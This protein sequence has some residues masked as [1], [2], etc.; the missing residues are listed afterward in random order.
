M[1]GAH[2]EHDA[3]VGETVGLVARGDGGDDVVPVPAA[4][5]VLGGAVGEVV[6]G[7]AGGAEVGCGCG[8]HQW[9]DLR[10]SAGAVEAPLYST[11]IP[12]SG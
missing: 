4:E 9:Y 1:D 11:G 10:V 12:P 3:V 7:G 6:G 5:R 2:V 8:A